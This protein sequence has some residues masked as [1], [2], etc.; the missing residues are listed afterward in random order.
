ML[1]PRFFT[2]RSLAILAGVGFPV[3]IWRKKPVSSSWSAYPA[4]TTLGKRQAVGA[5]KLIGRSSFSLTLF[6]IAG[7]W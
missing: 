3:R 7:T 1:R 6:R 2:R 4:H 5:D